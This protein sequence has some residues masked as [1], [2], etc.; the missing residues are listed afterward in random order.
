MKSKCIKVKKI[1]KYLS[2]FLIVIIAGILAAHA[3][4]KAVNSMTPKGGINESMYVDING[5]KQWI[6]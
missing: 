1:V 5:T 4:G 2:F 3:I 6:N